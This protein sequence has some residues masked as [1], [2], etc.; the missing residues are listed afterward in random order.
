M[1]YKGMQYDLDNS[2][3]SNPIFHQY[4]SHPDIPKFSTR[5][6]D[7]TDINS[8]RHPQTPPTTRRWSPFLT[9]M[10]NGALYTC[11]PSILRPIPGLSEMLLVSALLYFGRVNTRMHLE[12]LAHSLRLTCNF[13]KQCGSIERI[14]VAI[15][16]C[17][18]RSYEVPVVGTCASCGETASPSSGTHSYMTH[19]AV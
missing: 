18:R 3:L 7:L 6:S 12:P 16:S 8:H 19:I 17:V 4:S 5:F 1:V 2:I 14:N 13:Q 11:H 15:L 10:F 9:P